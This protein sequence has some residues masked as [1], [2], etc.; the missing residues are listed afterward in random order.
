MESTW[1]CCLCLK[2]RIDRRWCPNSKY[3][4]SCHDGV[5]EALYN[6]TD[7]S[8]DP[9]YCRLCKNYFELPPYLCVSCM[10]SVRGNRGCPSSYFCPE[11]HNNHEGLQ[12]GAINN[13]IC[14]VCCQPRTGGPQSIQCESCSQQLPCN[15]STQTYA[16]EF[17]GRSD[18]CRGCVHRETLSLDCPFISN[19]GDISQ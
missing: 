14:S 1:V 11:C 3:C 6:L 15:K 16:V 12:L 2:K 13:E 4:L 19:F 9:N 7:S 10:I 5:K 17:T 8:T 18:I